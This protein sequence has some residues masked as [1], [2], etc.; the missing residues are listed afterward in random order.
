MSHVVL[1]YYYSSLL[2]VFFF[3]SRRRHTRWNCDWSSDVCSSDLVGTRQD[4]AEVNQPSGQQVRDM[5]VNN[6]SSGSF[7]FLFT[8]Q[9]CY[10]LDIKNIALF[11]L[12][13]ACCKM[14]IMLMQIYA[15]K[16]QGLC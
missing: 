5:R 12:I 4:D 6:D 9:S 7:S 11:F 13:I 16:P 1:W 3:S 8:N 2:A 10:S 15:E 14:L